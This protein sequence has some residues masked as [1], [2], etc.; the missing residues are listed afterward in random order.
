MHKKNIVAIL[1]LA[2]L[3]VL[4]VVAGILV[5]RDGLAYLNE[6]NDPAFQLTQPDYGEGLGTGGIVVFV[7]GCLVAVGG[8]AVTIYAFWKL[9]QLPS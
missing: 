5:A 6:A 8:T 9:S 3:G 1:G 7:V 2:L 4:I